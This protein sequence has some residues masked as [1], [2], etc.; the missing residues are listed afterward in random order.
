MYIANDKTMVASVVTV[1][2]IDVA[3]KTVADKALETPN[4]S[5]K[6]DA[7]QRAVSIS[8]ESLDRLMLDIN[9]RLASMN[10]HMTFERDYSS[11]RNVFSLTRC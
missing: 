1:K 5:F 7:I 11:G 2:T 9:I 4:A 6:P 10:N 3:T 8:N